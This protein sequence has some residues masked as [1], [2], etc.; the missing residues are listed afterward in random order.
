M[1]G[2]SFTKTRGE[3]TP[4]A[5]AYR[6]GMLAGEDL[7]KREGRVEERA[8]LLELLQKRYY[9]GTVERGSPLGEAILKIAREVAEY[10]RQHP[11]GGGA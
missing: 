1:A 4:E 11:L 3:S 6:D 5:R 7:G 8:L 2:D 9:E 10:Y